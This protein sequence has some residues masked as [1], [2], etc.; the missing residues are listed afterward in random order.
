MPINMTD[1]LLRAFAMFHPNLK[2]LIDL[3]AEYEP[4]LEK[5]G[6]VIKAAE[7][8]GGSAYEAAVAA[9]PDL[10]AAIKNFA[11]SQ[12]ATASSVEEANKIVANRTETVTRHVFS[13]SP[14]TTE[15]EA[16]WMSGATPATSTDSRA[17]GN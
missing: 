14:L 9:A 2:P 5:L 11:S 6:P 13:A 8:E 12:P 17:G 7:E 1:G 3:I 15:E 16:A 10:A 4:Q